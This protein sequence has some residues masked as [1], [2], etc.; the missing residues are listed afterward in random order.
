MNDPSKKYQS[1]IDW[2]PNSPLSYWH[3]DIA[4]QI[5]E[6]LRIERWGDM[7]GWESCLERL[8]EIDPLTMDF[9][10]SVTIGDPGLMDKGRRLQLQATLMDLQPWLKG[11]FKL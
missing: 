7:P 1:L 2:L 11:P 8:P 3:T 10:E 4:E 6:Q 5:N 9:S